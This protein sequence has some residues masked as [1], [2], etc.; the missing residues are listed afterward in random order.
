MIFCFSVSDSVAVTSSNS[1][2]SGANFFTF[3]IT[4]TEILSGG[5]CAICS[6]GDDGGR[7]LF[8]VTILIENFLRSFSRNFVFY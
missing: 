4:G 7:G 6:F 8:S 5:D 1:R 2:S 3:A